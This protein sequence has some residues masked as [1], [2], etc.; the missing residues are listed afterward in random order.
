[1]VNNRILL[2][3]DGT[4]ASE[5][6]ARYVGEVLGHA[7]AHVRLLHVL[8]TPPLARTDV[9]GFRVPTREQPTRRQTDPFVRT[10][11]VERAKRAHPVLERMR[12]ILLD[13]GLGEE[14]L[15]LDFHS[16][17][18]E[19]SIP[20]ALLEQARQHDCDTIVVGYQKLPWYRELFYRHVGSW[21]VRH[22]R[23]H[24]VWVIE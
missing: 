10:P 18:P 7:D 17:A 24:A 20:R 19:E 2:A 13:E 1:M 14:Q 9:P 16:P 8:P 15:K 4:Q 12:E 22:A 21:L 11:A 6:A 23:E 3:I 5:R